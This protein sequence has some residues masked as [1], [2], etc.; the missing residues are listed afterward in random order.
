MIYWPMGTG[1]EKRG[2]WAHWGRLLKAA[3]GDG[4]RRGVQGW[5]D[6]LPSAA[7]QNQIVAARLA[8]HGLHAIDATS[9]VDLRTGISANSH[10]CSTAAASTGVTSLY[11][12]GSS[13]PTDRR[14][15]TL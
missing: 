13:A 12:V 9:L 7:V 8:D 10:P 5:E 2:P 14:C 15:R 11:K 3:L 1:V 4:A 6:S